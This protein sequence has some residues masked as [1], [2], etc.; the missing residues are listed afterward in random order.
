MVS[1][2]YPL[3][4]LGLD[5]KLRNDDKPPETEGYAAGIDVVDRLAKAL[6]IEAAGLLKRPVPSDG[7]S[8][9]P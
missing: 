4:R 5:A 7:G 1:V 8:P 3:G 2:A 6:G 9:R